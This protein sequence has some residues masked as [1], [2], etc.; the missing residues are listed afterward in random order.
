MIARSI[1]IVAPIINEWSSPFPMVIMMVLL[2][3]GLLTSYSFP[4]ENEF[5]PGE[6]QKEI[7]YDL[8]GKKAINSKN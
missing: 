4:N 6:Q 3:A 1:T 7:V 5:T 8:N 2:V